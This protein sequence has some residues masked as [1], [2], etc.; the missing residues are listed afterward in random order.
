E[1]LCKE[2]AKWPRGLGYLADQLKRAMASVVLNLAEGNARR[3]QTERRRFFE[4][5]RASLAEV[6]ACIDLMQAFGLT[7][8]SQSFKSTLCEISKMLWGLMK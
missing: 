4:V 1:E 2:G 3:S 8:N 5:S 7:N 6:S